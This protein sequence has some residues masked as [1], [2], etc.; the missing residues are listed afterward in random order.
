M[1]C[2]VHNISAHVSEQPAFSIQDISFALSESQTLAIIGESGSGKTSLLNALAGFL[3]VHQ[4]AV[5]LDDKTVSCASYCLPPN[6]RNTGMIFQDQNLLP[7]LT[8]FENIVLGMSKNQI[9]ERKKEIDQLITDL[10][11]GHHRD[12][13]PEQVSGGQQQRIALG[14]ALINNKKLL[15]FDEPFTGLDPH[16][17]HTLAR[18][19]N[20]S[21]KKYKRIA[22]LVTHHIEEAFLIADMIAVM[23]QGRLLQVN[24]PEVIYHE[25]DSL[26]IAEYIGPVNKL[27]VSGV[28]NDTVQTEFGM[29]KLKYGVS[30]GNSPHSILTRPDDFEI[31]PG[32]AWTITDVIFSG[33]SN[34]VLVKKQNVELQ[35]SLLH[36]RELHIGDSV[37]VT[38][39]KHHAYVAYDEFGNKITS[40]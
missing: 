26:E 10:C 14:R 1:K 35:I 40:V 17:T 5:I 8:L 21:V 29:V 25:P 32:G 34:T 22:I 11:V 4:G 3:P 19:I 16:R 24:T 15:L 9:Q 38:L 23:K 7:H 2:L 28:S 33:M 30:S 36:H 31:H 12:S 6:E 37:D 13:L 39:Q 27:P 20:D 18:T